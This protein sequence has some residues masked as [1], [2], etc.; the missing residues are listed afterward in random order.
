MSDHPSGSIDARAGIRQANGEVA[1]HG[2][3]F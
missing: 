1:D 3:R 2:F